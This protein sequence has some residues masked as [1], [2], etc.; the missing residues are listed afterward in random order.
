MGLKAGSHGILGT[1]CGRWKMQTG[2]MGSLNPTQNKRL[3]GEI[4]TWR[5]N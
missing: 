2:G 1:V 4:G 3:P 5:P